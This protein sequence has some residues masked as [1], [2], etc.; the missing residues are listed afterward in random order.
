MFYFLTSVLLY[1]RNFSLRDPLAS[2]SRPQSPRSFWPATGIASSG[3]VQ[4]RK[5]AIHGL[6]VKS[7]KSDWLRIWNEYSAHAQKIGSDHILVPR[8]R[9]A[10]GQH[11]KSRPLARPNS[12][13][14]R[15]TDFPLLCACSESSLTNLIGYGLNLLCLQSHSK[16]ECRWTWPELVIFSADLKDRGLGPRMVRPELARVLDPCR[17]SEWS[18][19][20]GTRMS[21]SAD[22]HYCST[23]SIS[24]NADQ[25]WT[26]AVT[27]EDYS[28][29]VEFH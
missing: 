19:S 5:F 26:K 28:S 21:A 11:W 10:F 14:P 18:W 20:L 13:S 12:G 2:H 8:G 1:A 17:R 6:P 25:C 22:K 3:F 29:L 27:I 7:G 24:T 23:W 4:H 9:D 15:F 16:P